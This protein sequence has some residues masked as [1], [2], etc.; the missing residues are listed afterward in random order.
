MPLIGTVLKPLPKSVLIPLGLT[1]AA[2]ATN[3]AILDKMFG[4]G[5]MTLKISNEEMK[6]MIKIV[7]HL[8]E[9]ALLIIGVSK[10]IKN[11]AKNTWT[12]ELWQ[13]VKAQLEQARAFNAPSPF[14]WFVNSKVLSRWT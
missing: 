1:T 13:Q 9:S 12:K 10:E 3:A 5:T 6:D 8:E 11:E 14:N 7:K 2:S 4:S